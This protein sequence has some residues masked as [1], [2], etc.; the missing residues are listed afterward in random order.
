[1]IIHGIRTAN[2]SAQII[3]NKESIMNTLLATVIFDLKWTVLLRVIVF[4]LISFCIVTVPSGCVS[5]YGLAKAEAFGVVIDQDGA[6]LPDVKVKAIWLPGC[7][8]PFV[9]DGKSKAVQ[10]NADG[11]WR[12]S[13]RNIIFFGVDAYAP[14][15]YKPWR[16]ATSRLYPGQCVSNVVFQFYKVL[17]DDP[18]KES[19]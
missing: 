8:I 3:R 19:K 9:L 13:R 4:A 12:C 15:G 16:L 7:M 14:K 18:V 2:N 17:P 5:P 6:P 10:V 1:M 11:S